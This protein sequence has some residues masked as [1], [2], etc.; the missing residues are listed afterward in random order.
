MNKRAYQSKCKKL[1]KKAQDKG[2]ELSFSPENFD[3]KRLNCLWYGG[4][5]ASI[6]VSDDLSVGIEINGDVYIALLDAKLST[7][8]AEVRDKG[9][10]GRFY[11]EMAPFIQNDAHLA[12]LI[13]S[14][15]L[16][17]ENNNWI[18]YDGEVKRD[19]KSRFV[20]LGLITDNIVNDDILCAI[21]EVLDGIDD[22]VE[23]IKSLVG[24]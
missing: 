12:R 8:I 19:G 24:D 20:D 15:R 11:S 5:V 21:D 13:D 7:D 14:G 2:L 4:C 3:H 10:G 16:V 18:E 17:I 6:K 1:F 9:N 23:D 22:I